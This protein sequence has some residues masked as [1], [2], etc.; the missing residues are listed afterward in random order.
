MKKIYYTLLL[1][2]FS[3]N[4][5]AQTI[6]SPANGPEDGLPHGMTITFKDG[7]QQTYTAK[8]L[9]LS[10]YKTRRAVRFNALQC[11]VESRV[12]LF[13]EFQRGFPNISFDSFR[14]G[15]DHS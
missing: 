1:A 9:D 6:V 7:T 13:Q 10:E 3:L 5:N 4:S 15:M 8:P 14:F 2:M 11:I 12:G